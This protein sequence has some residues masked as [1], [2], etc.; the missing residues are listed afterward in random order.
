MSSK[1][2]RQQKNNSQTKPVSGTDDLK[3][4]NGISATLEQRLQR[5]GVLTYDQLAG[6]TPEE[7]VKLLGNPEGLRERIIKQNWIGQAL[8]LAESKGRK[9]SADTSATKIPASDQ[10]YEAFAVELMIGAEH[11][12]IHTRVMQVSTG[13]EEIWGGWQEKRLTDFFV[14]RADL[15]LSPI[16]IPNADVVEP[17]SLPVETKELD[18][19]ATKVSAPAA[20][21]SKVKNDVKTNQL[22]KL[23]IIGQTGTPTHILQHGQPFGAKL[24]LHLA[25]LALLDTDTFT[26]TVT[27]TVQHL[28]GEKKSQTLGY[29]KGE[30][31]VSQ[32]S[33]L[34]LK[35][36]I[37][38]LGSYRVEAAVT[39]NKPA[40]TCCGFQVK[41]PGG[42][43]QV[44]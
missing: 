17:V 21:I 19:P 25:E 7:T 32:A 38:P 39:I 4:I 36:L 42:M 30:L 31:N 8:Q 43:L 20:Q 15:H 33:V 35:N 22:N 14:K 29:K 34:E 37:L 41:V 11:D 5:V 44:Y 9:P 13:D 3:V 40:A 12:V 10:T 1:H 26:Y 16:E 27:L 2:S 28:S 24:S 23:E 18:S 6:L